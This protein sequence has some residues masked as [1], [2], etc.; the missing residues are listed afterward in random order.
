MYE[1]EI[2]PHKI[3]THEN[4]EGS[5]PLQESLV[6][7]VALIIIGRTDWVA[8]QDSG[9]DWSLSTF[10]NDWKMNFKGGKIVVAYRYGKS[11]EM[12]PLRQ[13]IDFLLG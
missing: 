6:K 7:R 13:A 2:K 4:I 5:A 8:K 1:I 3:W 9:Y 12:E 10:S 11:S